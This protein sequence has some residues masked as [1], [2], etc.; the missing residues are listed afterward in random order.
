MKGDFRTNSGELYRTERGRT[1][2]PVKGLSQLLST[3]DSENF[4][5]RLWGAADSAV[6]LQVW[7]E[8]KDNKEV[9]QATD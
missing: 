3:R 1:Q 8:S 4:M 7:L 9:I 5:G 2:Y 6:Y